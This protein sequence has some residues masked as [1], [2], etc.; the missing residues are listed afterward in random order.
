MTKLKLFRWRAINR[1]QQKQ[2]GL[3]VA[4]S[5]AKARQQLM[6]QGLQS[7]TLQQNWQLSNK[8]KNAEICA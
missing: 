8:P 1:L 6:A 7:I 2:K 5:D 3:I 4:E